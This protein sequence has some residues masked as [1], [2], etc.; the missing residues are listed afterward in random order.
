MLASQNL[1]TG[2][3]IDALQVGLRAAADPLLLYRAG[4]CYL[5]EGQEYAALAA[6]RCAGAAPA[7]LSRAEARY[8]AGDPCGA[9]RD[10]AITSTLAPGASD[11]HYLAGRIHERQGDWDS[12]AGAYREAV[13]L[14]EFLWLDETS[15]D[16]M[17]AEAYTGWGYASY[18]A[19]GDL[20]TAVG[21]LM[22]AL[23][24]APEHGWALIRLCD[25]HRLAGDLPLALE[26]GARAVLAM[27]SEH[28][29]YFSRGRAYAQAGDYDL[30]RQDFEMALEIAPDYVLARDALAQLPGPGSSGGWR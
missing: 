9:L 2:W 22:M 10:L 13:L 12:A 17:M 16:Q 14:H 18:Q 21:L 20:A 6:W 19:Q 5:A 25:V 26:W 3:A 30:A 11:P 28:W 7:F 24:F 8:R 4:E 1:G 15:P 29:A 23:D 27:P